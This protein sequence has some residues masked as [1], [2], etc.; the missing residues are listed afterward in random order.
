M[1]M[2]AQSRKRVVTTVAQNN[3]IKRT[4][5]YLVRIPHLHH[6]LSVFETHVDT[7]KSP[8]P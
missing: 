4:H 5:E 3:S 2:A 8:T 6:V 7:L 1:R